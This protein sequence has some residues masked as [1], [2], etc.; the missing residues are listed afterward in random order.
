MEEK[1]TGW[2]RR[3]VTV[4]NLYRPKTH[5]LYTYNRFMKQFIDRYTWG[6]DNKR[7]YWSTDY[8]NGCLTSPRKADWGKC[9][10]KLE[11]QAQH[12]EGKRTLYYTNQPWSNLALFCC[13][14]DVIKDET[15][16]MLT[17]ADDIAEV[18][19]FL[20]SLFPDCYYEPSSSGHGMH[21]YL[22]VDF[23]LARDGRKVSEFAQIANQYMYLDSCSLAKL[24]R[25]YINKNY[26]ANFD[27]I[28]ASYSSYE[29]SEQSSIY[30]LSNM[31]VLCKQPRVRADNAHILYNMPILSFSDLLKTMETLLK[32]CSYP[33]E[34]I[35]SSEIVTLKDADSGKPCITSSSSYSIT[36]M[37]TATAVLDEDTPP[38]IADAFE[39]SRHICFQFFRDYYRQNR[40]QPTFEEY[41]L[42]YRNHPAST[43]VETSKAVARLNDVYEYTRRSF[44]A[45][46]VAE[47]IYRVGEYI[48]QLKQSI[49]EPQIEQVLNESTSYKYRVTYEDLDVGLGYFYRNLI[50]KIQQK[51]STG[52]ELTVPANDMVTWFRKLKQQGQITRSCNRTKATAI[53]VILQHI[54]WLECIDTSYSTKHH[55]S[56]RW[57]FTSRFPKYTEFVKQ[58]G[59]GNIE[60]ARSRTKARKDRHAA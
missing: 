49:A 26:H 22:L 29:Y 13:D 32:K 53:R 15:G 1:A 12:L 18:K 57:V 42:H 10:S 20:Q 47:S 21:Y 16:N 35:G 44:L 58:I 36:G 27:S 43:G 6:L 41:R 19:V 5:T 17:I 40:R 9:R 51:T 60:A 52:K 4:D 3:R 50:T 54:G 34:L 25:L 45:D 48:S 7:H 37:S 39:R 24:L 56:Q 2:K 30:K 8:I 28:K 55:I 23:T 11:H 46:K 59:E 33:E 14:V 38:D 31:G